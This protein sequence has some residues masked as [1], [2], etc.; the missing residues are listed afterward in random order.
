MSR[1]PNVQLDE[2]LENTVRGFYSYVMAISTNPVIGM[3]L[4]K[5]LSSYWTGDVTVRQ[6]RT[7]ALFDEIVTGYSRQF[8]FI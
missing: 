3:L 6:R 5:R 1:V 7:V 8:I 2:V 4:C